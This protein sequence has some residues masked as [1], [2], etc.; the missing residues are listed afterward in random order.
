[1]RRS[2]GRYLSQEEIKRIKYLLGSTDMTLQE[3]ATRMGCSKSSVVNINHAFQIRD[4]HGRRSFWSVAGY[5]MA[6]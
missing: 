4:Y 3:I 1:M 5:A 2:Q 6:S